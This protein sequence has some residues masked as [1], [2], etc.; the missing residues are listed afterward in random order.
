MSEQ[1]PLHVISRP[2]KMEHGSAIGISHRWSN[3]QY[4]AILTPAGIIGCGIYDIRSATTFDQ[5]VAI[6]RGTPQHPLV[7]PEDLFVA[8]IVEVS[9][10]AAALG[11]HHGMSGRDAVE[12]LLKNG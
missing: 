10:R 4:C 3:G 9:P 2:L 8:Q 1:Q 11:I 6:A 7:E 12:T 5:V